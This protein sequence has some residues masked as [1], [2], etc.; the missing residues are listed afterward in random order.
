MH[1]FLSGMQPVVP[2]ACTLDTPLPPS[3]PPDVPSVPPFA[4]PLTDNACA[5]SISRTSWAGRPIT[6]HVSTVSLQGVPVTTLSILAQHTLY[7]GP[8]FEPPV[9]CVTVSR[10]CLTLRKLCLGNGRSCRYAMWNKGVTCCPSGT[11]SP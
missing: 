3:P 11:F 1:C 4:L 2:H 5:S 9:I 10:P 8:S 6:P 7:P